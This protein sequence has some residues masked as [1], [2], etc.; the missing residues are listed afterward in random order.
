MLLEQLPRVMITTSSIVGEVTARAALGR[1]MLL[2][3]GVNQFTQ[4]TSTVFCLITIL[5]DQGIS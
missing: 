3:I 1:C 2:L 4:G 5:S